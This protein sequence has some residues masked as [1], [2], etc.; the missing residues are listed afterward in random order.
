MANARARFECLCY[1]NAAQGNTK[2]IIHRHRAL[3]ETEEEED[4]ES[5]YVLSE[6]ASPSLSYIATATSR[7][8][9]G[10]QLI[11]V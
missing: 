5:S 6:R 7:A 10:S 11:P 2:P 3:V 8:R 4:L 1:Y 9:S